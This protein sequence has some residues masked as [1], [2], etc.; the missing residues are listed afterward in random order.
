MYDRTVWIVRLPPQIGAVLNWRIDFIYKRAKLSLSFI[1][2]IKVAA[3]SDD[4]SE[5]A[6]VPTCITLTPECKALLKLSAKSMGISMSAIIEVA[7]REKIQLWKNEQ[8]L[9]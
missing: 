2:V 3:M 8:V 9:S 4:V 7:V 5:G 6:K 1:Y